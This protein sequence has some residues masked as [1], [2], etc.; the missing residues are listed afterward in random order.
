MERLREKCEL[1][2]CI[3]GEKRALV[4]RR[5]ALSC[6]IVRTRARAMMSLSLALAEAIKG[7]AE[8][9]GGGD[10]RPRHGDGTSRRRDVTA[11]R[12]HGASSP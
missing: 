9:R 7:T 6:V 11:T 12:R 1:G 3:L 2:E 5:T 8:K 4:G 10:W